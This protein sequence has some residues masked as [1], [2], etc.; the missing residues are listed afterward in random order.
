MSLVR[1]LLVAEISEMFVFS[2][3]GAWYE[4][5]GFFQGSDE[6][7]MGE[8]LSRFLT[9]QVLLSHGI[10]TKVVSNFWVTTF[11]LNGTEETMSIRRLTTS[12]PT[13]LLA[14]LLRSY[15]I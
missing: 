7:S 1:A 13:S 10:S 9:S 12:S 3:N 4:P 6:G 14:A 8:G 15:T 2:Q 5:D 11:W